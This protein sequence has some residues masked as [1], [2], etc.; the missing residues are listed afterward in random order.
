MDVITQANCCSK[1]AEIRSRTLRN[2]LST[3]SKGTPVIPKTLHKK[4]TIEYL[5]SAPWRGLLGSRETQRWQW[6][7]HLPGSDS[8]EKL[9]QLIQLQVLIAATCAKAGEDN[10]EENKCL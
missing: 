4:R 2:L 7:M 10:G 1:N 8:L 6:R 5:A 3:S 9:V